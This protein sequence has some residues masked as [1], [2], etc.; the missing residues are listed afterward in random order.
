MKKS[1]RKVTSKPKIKDNVY[2]K[3]LFNDDYQ[4][5]LLAQKPLSVLPHGDSWL[6]AL[7][8]CETK[9]NEFEEL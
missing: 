2:L 9:D 4:A 8:K 1:T 3:I 7:E 5:E 6:D